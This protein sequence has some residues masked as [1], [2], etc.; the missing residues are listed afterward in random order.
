MDWLK[1]STWLY[2]Q[3]KSKSSRSSLQTRFSSFVITQMLHSGT[4]FDL[5]TIQQM[6]AQQVPMV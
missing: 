2:Q 3:F 5:H 4:M 1:G 6:T